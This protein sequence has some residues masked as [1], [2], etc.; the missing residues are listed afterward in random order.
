[1][2][3]SS[4]EEYAIYFGKNETIKSDFIKEKKE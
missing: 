2:I 4:Q 1:M 3:T